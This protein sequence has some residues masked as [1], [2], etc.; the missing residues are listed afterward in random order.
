[1]TWKTGRWFLCGLG[2]RLSRLQL[3]VR[4]EPTSSSKTEFL[5]WRE[6]NSLSLDIH[7]YVCTLQLWFHCFVLLCFSYA[8]RQSSSVDTPYSLP[9]LYD[10]IR[11]YI[12]NVYIHTE[13]ILYHCDT[14]ILTYN[15]V[16][17]F[18][19]NIFTNVLYSWNSQ[20]C[21]VTFSMYCAILKNYVLY[22]YLYVCMYV[23]M[24]VCTYV[25]IYVCMYVCM[26]ML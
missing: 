14:I 19:I 5:K 7:T 8:F 25:C 12:N 23:C 20:M 26:Y 18:V 21:F 1:M 4:R 10:I 2:W 17:I 13:C 6:Q 22:L 16:G 11:T 9:S 15:T 3:N 24:Y